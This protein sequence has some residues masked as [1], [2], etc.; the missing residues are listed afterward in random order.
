MLSKLLEGFSD[1]V[2]VLLCILACAIF[3]MIFIA[4]TKEYQEVFDKGVETYLGRS[5]PL[6]E[7]GGS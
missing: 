3:L 1:I 7:G 6:P 2:I 5:K 4:D